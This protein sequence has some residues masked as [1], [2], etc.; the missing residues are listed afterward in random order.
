M[1]APDD[2]ARRDAE[3]EVRLH[4]ELRAAELEGE[5]VPSG[6]A[7]ARARREFGDV[8][9]TVSYMA[10]R[11][12]RRA[13]RARRRDPW[14]GLTRDMRLTLRSFFRRPLVPALVVL[15][16]AL[17]IGAN[18]AVYSLLDAL[19]FR[20]LPF[21]DGDRVVRMRDATIRPDGTPWP[22]NTSARSFTFLRE[23]GIFQSITAQRYRLFRLTGDGEPA[24]LTG[25][26]VSADWTRT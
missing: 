5:G 17:G 15:T 16:L 3:E 20:P 25:I 4:L 2:R 26:G 7:R 14:T 12:R 23:S 13:R 22:Y 8:D 1:A 18:T 9:G 19:V 21:G 10:E 11:E 6:E 24:A